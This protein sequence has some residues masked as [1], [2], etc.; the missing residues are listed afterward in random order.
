M[1]LVPWCLYLFVFCGIFGVSAKNQLSAREYFRKAHKFASNGKIERAK[2][3]L[4]YVLVHPQVDEEM[5]TK[6]FQEYI[7]LFDSI[8]DGTLEAAKLFNQNGY[9]DL[10]RSLAQS[11]IARDPNYSP[12]YLLLAD[13]TDT[14]SVEG[15]EE[16]IRYLHKAIETGA[17]DSQVAL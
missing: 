14:S 8:V 16:V 10:A 9:R 11:T 7:Q 2:E 6:A 3:M 4:S 1:V 15:R 17:D 5:H 12:G 13:L